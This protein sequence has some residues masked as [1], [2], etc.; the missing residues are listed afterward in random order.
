MI[1]GAARDIHVLWTLIHLFGFIRY[2]TP[3]IRDTRQ[4][5]HLEKVKQWPWIIRW[6]L[7]ATGSSKGTTG[8]LFSVQGTLVRLHLFKDWSLFLSNKILKFML[9]KSQK[10]NS[11]LKDTVLCIHIFLLNIKRAIRIMAK[12]HGP[13]NISILLAISKGREKK[14]YCTVDMCDKTAEMAFSIISISI[15][16]HRDNSALNIF[17]QYYVNICTKQLHS[18]RCLWL[19]SLHVAH[20]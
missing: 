19:T 2:M 16:D 5:W 18:R 15:S 1:P 13:K 10:F 12:W 11:N 3:E 20:L 7:E 17:E 14:K 8:W 9:R 4:H 6:D